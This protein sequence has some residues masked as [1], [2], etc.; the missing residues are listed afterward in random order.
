MF[1]ISR[2]QNIQ[3][4]LLLVPVS[5]LHFFIDFRL[6]NEK[7]KAK[8]T[9]ISPKYK[10]VWNRN[11][12]TLPLGICFTFRRIVVLDDLSYS[13]NTTNVVIPKARW[14]RR[15]FL[16][17][18]WPT[19][20]TA[21]VPPKLAKLID[22]IFCVIRVLWHQMTLMTSNDAYDIKIW[23]QSIWPILVSKE[24]SGL[25][26]LHLTIWIWQKNSLNIKKLIDLMV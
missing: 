14:G 7:N 3:Q 22:V 5:L 17:Q 16:I 2:F 19:G 21:V 1:N 8:I 12:E 4:I 20:C 26:Q 18:T 23:H 24:A 11:T 13:Y 9:T 15:N 25:Q 10:F 6:W